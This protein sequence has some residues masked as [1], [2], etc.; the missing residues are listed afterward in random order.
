MEFKQFLEISKE[1]QYNSIRRTFKKL[2]YYFFEEGDY[3]LNVVAIRNVDDFNS[4]KFNDVVAVAYLIDGIKQVDIFNATTDPG[5]TY[6]TKPI[7]NKGTAILLPQQSITGLKLGKHKGYEALV[8]NRPFNV[9]RDN[10]RNILLSELSKYTMDE[11]KLLYDIKPISSNESIIYNKSGIKIANI[12]F[13]RFGI[14]FHRASRWKILE[15][16]GL[17]SAGCIVQQD[18]YR[19]NKVFMKLVKRSV[20]LYGSMFTMTLITNDK[21]H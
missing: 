21:L 6:R 7:N 18:S 12:E 16:I 15:Y 3:N 17:Y 5:K 2:G 10:D 9:I 1:R 13:G 20:K 11:I 19:Y 8:Q 4:T 14:N